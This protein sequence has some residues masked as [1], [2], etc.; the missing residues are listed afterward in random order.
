M[1]VCVALAGANLVAIY[2]LYPESNF[3]RT[4]TN[5]RAAEHDSNH[6]N[7]P[8]A[9]KVITARM[10]TIN[11]HHVKIVPKPWLSIWT[12]VIT[13]NHDAGLFETFFRPFKTLLSP[14][15][16]FAVFVY[17]T[18]LAA[19]VILMYVTIQSLR[20]HS[21][22]NNILVSLFRICCSRHHTC[23]HPLE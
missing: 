3:I 23:S 17:G 18:S 22:L 20:L 19:Q 4:E 11:Q 8:E 5:S 2:L 10:E 9:E 12:S 7:D 16:L 6:S 21:Y 13:I 15:I 14:T 1:W